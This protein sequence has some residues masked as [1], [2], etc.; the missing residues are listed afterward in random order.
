MTA[1][2]DDFTSRDATVVRST[3]DGPV[4]L[5]PEILARMAEVVEHAQA[6]G[7]SRAYRAAWVRFEDWCA[8]HGYTALPARPEVIA[9]YLVV[10][11]DT[12][13]PSGE[14]AYAPSTLSKWVSA[15]ADRHRRVGIIDLPTRHEL[16]RETL[17]GIKR[18][19]ATAGE[20]P[21]RPRAPLLTDD[22]MALVTT[23]REQVLGWAD[24]VV[25]RRDSALLL[26]GLATSIRRSELV[27]LV[28]ADVELHRADG[29]HVT[30][31]RSK[32]DQEGEGRLHPAPRAEDPRR[33]PACAAVR[34]AEVVAASDRYGRR[35]VI[36]LLT[37]APSLE[38][39]GH[40]CTS[41]DQVAGRW[42]AA[43]RPFF[44]SIRRNGLV[45]EQ[46]LAASS[47]HAIVRR[48]AERAGI[49]PVVVEQLGAHSLRSGHVSQALRNGATFEEVMA[50]TGHTNVAT[51][52][53]YR[54]ETAP[55][56]ANSVTKL[57][58]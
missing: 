35:G 8:R 17:A 47:V 38:A 2:S 23:A 33:C 22:I 5:P 55:L 46:A 34:W 1:P 31:T 14:R 48:R 3:G 27:A 24:A 11:R 12:V 19:Y 39:T 53:R 7:T 26:V 10:A 16:V 25:E 40:V 56:V 6:S 43:R 45:G 4:A 54:H 20:R 30:V 13:K 15:I 52:L 42:V 29:L 28:G 49:D 37:G 32:T 36:R 57:G 50:Q 58:L 21:R 41:P 51:V 18:E 44:R 9:A